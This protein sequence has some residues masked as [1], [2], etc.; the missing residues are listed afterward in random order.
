MEVPIGIEPT[1]T[2]LQAAALPSGPRTI[3]FGRVSPRLSQDDPLS[4]L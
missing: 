2:G 3:N 4:G 1:T